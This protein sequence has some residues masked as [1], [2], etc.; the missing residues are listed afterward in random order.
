MSGWARLGKAFF[1]LQI[2]HWDLTVQ[3]GLLL[4]EGNL[5]KTRPA[6]CRWCQRGP[7]EPSDGSALGMTLPKHMPLFPAQVLRIRMKPRLH[8][9]RLPEELELFFTWELTKRTRH[10]PPL[11]TSSHLAASPW[12]RDTCTPAVFQVCKAEPRPRRQWYGLGIK[13][14]AIYLHLQNVSES[15]FNLYFTQHQNF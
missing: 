14:F 15:N 7:Q 6:A 11:K 8:L 3:S 4:G 10:N 13:R 5:W 1:R 9:Q 12:R 2:L